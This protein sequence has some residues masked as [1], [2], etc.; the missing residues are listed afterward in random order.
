MNITDGRKLSQAAKRRPTDI[1]AA[2]QRTCA[3]LPLAHLRKKLPAFGLRPLLVRRRERATAGRIGAESV[4]LLSG[5]FSLGL[6][7][8]AV[9]ALPSSPI[10]L[11]LTLHRWRFRVLDL[12]PMR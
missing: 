5:A 3:D 7:I 9:C 10:L 1:G 12:D 2:L 6:R 8:F 4:C 11:S